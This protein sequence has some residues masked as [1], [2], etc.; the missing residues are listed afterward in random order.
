MTRSTFG[1]TCRNCLKALAGFALLA[2]VG[3]CFWWQAKYRVA[4]EMVV[5]LREFSTTDYP[6]NPAD[7]SALHGRYSGRQLRLT[8]R[9]ETH[10]DFRL[11]SSDTNNSTIVWPNV[12]VSLFATG[13]PEWTRRHAGNQL[14]ALTDRE[15]NRQQVVFK[16]G[17]NRVEI[18]GGD[19]WERT[20]LFTA[21]IAKNCLNAG[22]WELLLFTREGGGKKLYYQAWFTFPLGHY[23]RLVERNAGV[24]YRDLWHRLEHWRDPEGTIVDLA[25]LR[26]VVSEHPAAITEDRDGPVLTAGEQSRKVR[27]T[28][29][30]NVRRYRDWF[31]GRPVTFGSFIK[32][33]RY[34]N[35]VP[36]G[37]EYWR[38]REFIGGTWRRIESPAGP[39]PLDE[40]ELRFRDARTGGTHRFLVGGFAARDL[41]QLR[42]ADNANG[43]YRP[44]GIAVPPFFQT[45]E[46]LEKSPPARSPYYSVLLD[47]ADRW[48]NHHRIG[49]DGPVLHRDEA[50]PGTLHLYLLSYERHALVAHFT[51]KIP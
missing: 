34:D 44:M 7:L 8:Q 5:S 2:L 25:G 21:E 11:E 45:I 35:D 4:D 31:D 36:H 47:Q 17:S 41:P 29:V 32:P 48:L 16:P 13:Q 38:V 1:R 6:E 43:L 22:L 42:P 37:N 20:N 50:E 28:Q 26:R 23:R 15:W 33:G 12:D 46:D 27:T 30:R 49:I 18:L 40:L 19:G 14:I 24:P 3:G 39:G 51:I 9:S 10:F